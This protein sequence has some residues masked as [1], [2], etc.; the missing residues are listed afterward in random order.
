MKG[1]K[2]DL[3]K[4]LEERLNYLEEISKQS[5]EFIVQEA[6]I[7]YIEDMEDIQK[8]SVL[9]VLEKGKPRKIYTTEE[10]TQKLGF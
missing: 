5:K 4:N 2:I 3:P 1:L 10:L 8:H 6:L 7:Q 9:E